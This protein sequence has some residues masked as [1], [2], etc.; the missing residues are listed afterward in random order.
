MERNKKEIKQELPLWRGIVERTRLVTMRLQ[1]RSLALLCGL[2]I[3]YCCE[4]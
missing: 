1:V 2:R 4:L 3:W